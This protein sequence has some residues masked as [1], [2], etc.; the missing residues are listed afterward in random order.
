[1][2]HRIVCVGLLLFL[3]LAMLP[4]LAQEKTETLPT[5][6]VIYIPY[7]QLEKLIQKTET[8]IYLPYKDYQKLMEEVDRARRLPPELPALVMISNVNY[9]GK[10]VGDFLEINASYTLNVLQKGWHGVTLGLRNVAI[11]DA[12]LDGKPALLQWKNDAYELVFES[13]EPGKRQLDITMVVAL[14]KSL[15]FRSTAQFY[16]PRAPIA[17]LTLEIPTAKEEEGQGPKLKIDI[18]PSLL[19]KQTFDPGLAKVEALLGNTDEVRI[20]WESQAERKVEIKQILHAENITRLEIGENFLQLRA[21]VRY[22]LIQGDIQKLQLKVPQG[23]RVLGVSSLQGTAVRDWNLSEQDASLVVNLVEKLADKG[24]NKVD[25][26][27]ELK[28]EKIFPEMEKKF[29]I[30]SLE[31]LGVEREKGF[32]TVA[33]NDLNTIKILQRKDITQIDIPDLPPEVDRQGVQFAFK[34]LKRPFSLELELE[35]IEPEY[36]VF[37]NVYGY[38]DE[39][40]YKLYAYF[41]YQVKKSRIFGSKIEIPQGFLLFDVKAYNKDESATLD[42]IKEY[43]EID[44]DVNQE[45]KHFLSITFK[46]GIRSERLLLK[47]HLQ[48]KLDSQEKVREIPLPVF[49]VEG[50]AR[51]MGNIGL[52]VHASYNI[53]T[54]DKSTKNVSPLDTSELFLQGERPPRELIKTVNIGV[55]YFDHPITAR[56]KIEKRDPLVTAEIYNYVSVEENVL[57]NRFRILY[58]VK[59]TG[60]KEFSFT[61]PEEIAKDVPK[62]HVSDRN[63]W[64][65]EIRIDEQKEAK[66]FLYT[67]ATQRDI[68]KQEDKDE[69]YEIYVVYEKKIPQ[70]ETNRQL[71]IGALITQNTKQE[72]GFI[73]FKKN[74]NFSMSFPAEL[75]KGLETADVQDPNYR[76]EKDSVLAIFK[77][78]AHPY[79]LTMNL[80][81][82]EFEPV[83]NTVINR[84]HLSTTVNKDFTTRNEAVVLVVNN[85]KQMLDFEVPEESKV[86]SVSRLKQVNAYAQRYDLD[87]YLESLTW[88]KSE[89]K[90]RYRVNI[91]TN[92]Q[93]NAPF[94]LVIKYEGKIGEGNM[95]YRGKLSMLPLTFAADVPVSYFRWDLGL[96]YEYQYVCFKSNLMRRYGYD[97]YGIWS[98]LAPLFHSGS[99]DTTEIKQDA[100]TGVIPIYD[101]Q[102]KLFSFNRLNSGGTISASYAYDNLLYTQELLLFILV[103]VLMVFVPR[104]KMLSRLHVFLIL[105]VLSL[106]LSAFNL[107]GYE[108]LYITMLWATLLSGATAILIHWGKLLGEKWSAIKAVVPNKIIRDGKPAAK[109]AV[110]KDEATEPAPKETTPPTGEQKQENK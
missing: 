91:A 102:G 48:R 60:V 22:D 109:E 81:R 42:Q 10:V 55:R 63:K 69:P 12:Q 45:K 95:G 108:Q 97:D 47:I 31:V 25:L 5:E 76:G 3:A 8:G 82:L 35:K 2:K 36:E 64:I 27:L 37:T 67:V 59:Y 104:T 32:Y 92:V 65:K 28:L 50:A 23:F 72:H 110:K 40:L 73:V 89:G 52:G 94:V 6:R 70:V 15:G 18:Y 106:F 4:L 96:P 83:L 26:E 21:K 58:T 75:M 78:N 53:T 80:Q 51:E 34:Y 38:L 19:T 54:I 24:E 88:S 11:K 41:Q 57:K 33:V 17:R 79:L 71:P 93:K 43:R 77:Y 74:N 98:S 66:T 7:Q 49:R 46:K 90:N 68:V 56:F 103:C 86:T 99:V 84:L 87:R 62:S 39:S 107:Q 105:L 16:I 29:S 13:A 14:V 61:L 20:Q 9:Q 1:M 85:S 30:P 101:I 100:E 44:E